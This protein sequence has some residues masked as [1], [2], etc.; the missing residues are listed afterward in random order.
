[1]CI[2]NLTARADY[3]DQ[4]PLERH[5]VGDHRDGLG[6]RGVG[7][8]PARDLIQVVADAR[9]LQIALA[10]DIGRRRGP[11][12]RPRHGLPQQCGHR[13]AGRRRLRLA[14]GK[15]RRRDA[16]PQPHG[17]ALSHQRTAKVERRQR[18]PLLRE[19]GRG[20]VCRGFEGGAQHPLARRNVRTL[21]GLAPDVQASGAS[22]FR[23]PVLARRFPMRGSAALLTD[24]R[25]SDLMDRG[26]AGLPDRGRVGLIGEG[27]SALVGTLTL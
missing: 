7:I 14:G 16:D 24:R 9:D 22:L 1:M 18:P 17:A 26:C 25:W 5:E 2:V 27:R 12:P 11:G 6:R 21:R 4:R 15:L 20:A 23:D 13:Q 8:R 3:R 19:P 10:L